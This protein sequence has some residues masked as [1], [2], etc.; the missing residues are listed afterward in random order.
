MP[1]TGTVA[2]LM[3]I[4]DHGMTSL[5]RLMARVVQAWAAVLGGDG[6]VLDANPEA[7]G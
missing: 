5:M 3:Y 6:D 7:A 4:A 2:A 1:A